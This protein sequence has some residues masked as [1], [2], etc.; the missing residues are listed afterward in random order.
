MSKQVKE[1]KDDW[2]RARVTKSFK[3]EFKKKLEADHI[4]EADFVM[5]CAMNYMGIK[6]VPEKLL[7]N[8]N[9]E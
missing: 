2:I 3:A 7:K 6:T 9:E 1:L 8:K 5:S 4:T